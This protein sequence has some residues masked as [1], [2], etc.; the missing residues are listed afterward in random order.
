MVLHLV[1]VRRNVENHIWLSVICALISPFLLSCLTSN[2]YHF[3]LW[4]TLAMV[5]P[6]FRCPVAANRQLLSHANKQGRGGGITWWQVV[7]SQ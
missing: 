6:G 1:L 2:P 5:A 4:D 7:A 3:L